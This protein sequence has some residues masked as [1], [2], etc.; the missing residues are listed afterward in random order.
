MVKFVGNRDE[1]FMY[2]L[3]WILV[4]ILLLILSVK[5]VVIWEGFNLGRFGILDNEEYSVYVVVIF[6][7][8]V[9]VFFLDVD[10]IVVGIIGG[11]VWRYIVWGIGIFIWD[12]F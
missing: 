8:R 2:F 5:R 1:N 6:C 12:I 3:L 11:W 7:S 4:W 9:G 10:W